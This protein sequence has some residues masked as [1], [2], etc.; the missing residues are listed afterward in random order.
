[1]AVIYS[2]GI[3]LDGYAMGPAGGFDWGTPDAEVFASATDDVRQ[4][5]AH[6]LGRRLYEAMSYWET[7]QDLD[8][9]EQEFARL[10]K[11]LP[12]V[13]FST[14]LTTVEGTNIRLA[15]KGI[16]QEIAELS[17]L[18][19]IAVG[20]PELAHVV[21]DLGLIDEYRPRISQVLVGGGTPYFS[22][23]AR[24]VPLELVGSRT[25]A[26]GVVQPRY[27]VVR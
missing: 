13:V 3:T 1:M 12:K 27:R 19:D 21:A 20:G 14:T 15:T 17:P 2:L 7:A 8:P 16:A 5:G 22:Q 4:L 9:A 11:A 10:W 25:F 6:L 24:E 23:S 26:C 18:G